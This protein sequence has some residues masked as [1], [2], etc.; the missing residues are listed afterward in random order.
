LF[1][2][3]FFL[4]FLLLLFFFLFFLFFFLLFF[5]FFFSFSFFYGAA[6]LVVLAFSTITFHL[7]RKVLK[8]PV[9]D[10]VTSEN[11]TQA[12]IRNFMLERIKCF[13]PPGCNT[14]FI[15]IINMEY[16]LLNTT[17]SSSDCT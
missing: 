2:F 15:V 1:L 6:T 12:I 4:I 17:A 13:E 3:F 7:R 9:R 5:S 11:I 10:D 8:V 16:C 14:N